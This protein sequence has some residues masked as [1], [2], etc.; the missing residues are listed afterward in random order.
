MLARLGTDAP[1]TELPAPAR[2]L[3][4]DHLT[5]VAPGEQTAIVKDVS[6]NLTAGEALGVIGPSGTGKTTL[7]RALVG[8]WPPARGTVRVDGAELDHWDPAM[9]GRHVGFVSQGV[10]LFDGTIAENIARM[11][12][13]PDSAAVL[14]AARQAG[15]HDMIQ[16]LPSGYDTRIGEGGAALSAGQR[17]R[18]ALARALYGNPFLL[19]LDEPNSNLDS[20]G[21]AAL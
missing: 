9:L 12:P 14:E 16:L 1:K 15:A 6:F 2:S 3:D 5:V 18:V 20:V 17:Q 21:E 7:V 13:A 19:V 10:E 4:V 8:V 11:A